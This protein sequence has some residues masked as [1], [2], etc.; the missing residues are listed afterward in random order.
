MEKEKGTGRKVRRKE[1][2][3][4]LLTVADTKANRVAS[5]TLILMLFLIFFD[6]NAL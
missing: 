5:P 4:V 6:Q 1:G 3:D 2:N